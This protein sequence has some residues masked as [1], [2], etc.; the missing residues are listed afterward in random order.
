MR[1]RFEGEI[2]G[3]GTHAGYRIVVGD[4]AVSPFGHLADVMVEGPDRNRTLIAPTTE[5][6]RAAAVLDWTAID[7]EPHR[8][9][10]SRARH[11]LGVRRRELEPR[12]PA[13]AQG[14]ELVGPAALTAR[15]ALADGA[16]LTLR[17]NLTDTELAL[18]P[19]PASARRLLSTS[20][21]VTGGWPAWFVD[22]T[23]D[24]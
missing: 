1:Y 20:R 11:R 14:G 15:W 18:P 19:A 17:A 6:A 12:L 10:L 2:Y 3:F 22:W 8:S 13:L 9:A 4:W 21:R 16:T 24:R 7:R 5:A 23:V